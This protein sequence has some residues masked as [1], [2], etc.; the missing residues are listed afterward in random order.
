LLLLLVLLFTA[1]CSSVSYDKVHFEPT[2]GLKYGGL[3]KP[4]RV[5]TE[6]ANQLHERGYIE[7]GEAT[8]Q[9]RKSNSSSVDATHEILA[10]A[11]AH[12]GELVSL[13]EDN[14]TASVAETDEGNCD[15]WKYD[16]VPY[17]RRDYLGMIHTEYR[18]EQVCAHHETEHHQVSVIRSR[19][20]VWR[21]EPALAQNAQIIDAVIVGDAQKLNR[22]LKGQ[23]DSGKTIRDLKL[24]GQAIHYGRPKLIGPLVAA[25]AV[26]DARDMW[27]AIK[28]CHD[29]LGSL[30]DHGAQVNATIQV[31]PYD[32]DHRAGDSHM[33][34]GTLLW[35]A[36]RVDCAPCVRVL[37]E[38]GANPDKVGHEKQTT[39]LGL[40]IEKNNLGVMRQLLDHRAAVNYTQYSHSPLWNA[41]NGDWRG[42]HGGSVQVVDLLLQHGADPNNKNDGWSPLGTAAARDQVVI[43]KHL[44]QHG[45]NPN[46]VSVYDRKSALQHAVEDSG[47]HKA[48]II[49][50]L[51]KAG[52]R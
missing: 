31:Q 38:H 26:V 28:W 39:P 19:A 48:E 12:G 32:V 46:L 41:V 30:L 21:N 9:H 18:T 47:P 29:C 50:L 34:P 52:A 43:V 6:K 3:S 15:E 10:L 35:Q 25:G 40:A 17:Y 13:R 2:I 27:A 16:S 36:V 23:A 49:A 11:A 42:A 45:A 51:K 44:L 37:L 1:A 8:V 7:I 33:G 4:A 20:D 22:L 14:A 24:V 5:T